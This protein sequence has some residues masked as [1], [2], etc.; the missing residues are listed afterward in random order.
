MIAMHTDKHGMRGFSLLEVAVVM[1]IIVLLLGSILVPLSTQVE[2]KQVNDTQRTMD[3][4]RE[5]LIG[6]AVSNG[7]LPCPA[8]SATNGLEDRT[9]GTCTGGKRQGYIPWQTLGI[10][11]SDAWGH[12]YRYSV[13]LTY[14]NSTTL[15]SLTTTPDI[16]IQT[17]NAAGVLTTLTTANSVS[18]VIISHGKNGYGSVN[19]NG[20]AQALPVNW[21]ASNTD[22]NTNATG[23]TS[24]VSRVA[25]A[26]NTTGTGGEFDDVLVWLPRYTLANRM[27]AAEKLP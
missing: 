13:T 6:Y 23:T 10:S 9:G 26:E 11:S 18:A 14:A 22:E 19:T 8:I 16:T 4:I 24:F 5:A 15:F 27:V 12:L 7:Y 20:T 17:R 25:Q 21:P 2:Q 3:E 1:L